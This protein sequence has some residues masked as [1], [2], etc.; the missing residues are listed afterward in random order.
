MALTVLDAIEDEGVNPRT[1][2]YKVLATDVSE[3][4]LAIGRQGLFER[5]QLRRVPQSLRCQHFFRAYGGIAISDAIQARVVFRRLNL[6]KPP[7]PF[8]GT[9]DAIFCHE[10]LIP[11]VPKARAHAVE[12]VS[13]MLAEGGFIRTGFEHEIPR[14]ANELAVDW[15]K[16]QPPG[17]TPRSPTDC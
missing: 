4:M 3:R 7:Y 12:A 8:A 10:A 5:A 2:D 6:A 16:P 9:F 15:H 1:V 17:V 14:E 11:M 13:E